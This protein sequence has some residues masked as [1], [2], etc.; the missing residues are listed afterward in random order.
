MVEPIKRMSAGNLSISVFENIGSET[1]KK[2][3]S[4]SLQKSFKKDDKWVNKSINLNSKELYAL[5]V[6]AQEIAKFDAIRQ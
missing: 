3:N 6:L 2:Y 4:Y 1:G 5:L